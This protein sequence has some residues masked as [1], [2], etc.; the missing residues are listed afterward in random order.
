[1]LKRRRH[2]RIVCG[3]S[4][5][6][7]CASPEWAFVRDHTITAVSHLVPERFA[8]AQEDDALLD[9]ALA[10]SLGL[11]ARNGAP[12][13]RRRAIRSPFEWAAAEDGDDARHTG[14]R[15]GQ[16]ARQVSAPR[17]VS[18]ARSIRQRGE[19]KIPRGAA[20]AGSVQPPLPPL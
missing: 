9:H 3:L 10:A 14:W 4:H 12:R 17:V 5:T 13:E 19:M 11:A 7:A 2:M 8:V 6:C 18:L 16:C 1:M 15:F 20:R